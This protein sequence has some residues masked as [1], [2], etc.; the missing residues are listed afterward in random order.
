MTGKTLK[1][2]AAKR[3]QRKRRIRS[4][5]SGCATLPRISVFRSN[6]F[7]SAQ[8]INDEQGVTLAAVHSKTLGLRA[9]IESAQKAAEVF[10]KTLKDAGINEVTFDRN[11]FL[12][13]G[14]V[15]AFAETLRANEIKF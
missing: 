2:K 13:H 4:K 12:Y 9:N 7:I 1:I 6:R 10:A 5:I 3:L 15:K 11:G 8:A 14:V